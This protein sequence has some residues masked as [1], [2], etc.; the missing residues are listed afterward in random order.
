MD[1]VHALGVVA[2]GR[3]DGVDDLRGTDAWN[4]SDVPIDTVGTGVATTP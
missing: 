4:P 1:G 3:D 2:D